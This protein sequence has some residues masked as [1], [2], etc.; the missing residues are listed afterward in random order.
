MPKRK[1][2]MAPVAG[3]KRDTTKT[4]RTR[5]D[6]KPAITAN[7]QTDISAEQFERDNLVEYCGILN[8]LIG[9]LRSPALFRQ[10]TCFDEWDR[11]PSERHPGP[12]GFECDRIDEV[13]DT[14]RALVF[15]A[16]RSQAP[17]LNKLE[18]WTRT[19]QKKLMATDVN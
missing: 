1:S 19:L 13:L 3:R 17:V 15:H 8:Q 16:C 11:S 12:F 14:L 10:M 5:R 4:R 9:F 7:Y 2:T 18:H 6:R